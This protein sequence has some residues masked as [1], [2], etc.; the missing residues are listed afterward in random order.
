MKNVKDYLEE[1]DKIA[2][3]ENNEEAIDFL[4][5]LPKE[6]KQGFRKGLLKLDEFANGYETVEVEKNSFHYKA[7][8]TYEYREIL[9]LGAIATCTAKEMNKFQS[10]R[11]SL[12]NPAS[13][14]M[15][16]YFKPTWLTKVIN[17]EIGRWWGI[18]SFLAVK[19][20]EKKGYINRFEPEVRADLLRNEPALWLDKIQVSK[21]R[22]RHKLS[23]RY[24][25]LSKEEFNWIKADLFL[26]FEYDLVFNGNDGAWKTIFKDWCEQGKIKR[27]QLITWTFDTFHRPFNRRTASFFRDFLDSLELSTDEKLALQDRYIEMLSNA[28]PHHVSYALKEIKKL[29]KLAN[30][31]NENLVENLEPILVSDSKGTVKN[32]LMLLERTAKKKKEL[33]PEICTTALLGL[34]SEDSDIQKRVLAILEKFGTKGDETLSDE[35]MIYFENIHPSLQPNFQPFLGESHAATNTES[36]SEVFQAEKISI[37][38]TEFRIKPIENWEDWIYLAGAVYEN[39]T[40]KSVEV[41][42]LF[43]GAVRLYGMPS[44][45]VLGRMKPLIQRIKKTRNNYWSQPQTII[46]AFIKVIYWM[47]ETQPKQWTLVKQKATNQFHDQSFRENP[48][49][50][51]LVYRRFLMYLKLV[52]KKGNLPVL[53]AP[54]HYHAW[55]D[56]VIFIEKLQ[57]YFNKNQTPIILDLAHALAKLSLKDTKKAH[58]QAQKIGGKLG[59]I[60]QVVLGNSEKSPFDKSSNLTISTQEKV[61]IDWVL[62]DFSDQP[63]AAAI[64]YLNAFRTRFPDKN[65]TNFK[66]FDYENDFNTAKVGRYLWDSIQKKE[67]YKDSEG[68]VYLTITRNNFFVKTATENFPPPEDELSILFLY[69]HLWVD[70]TLFSIDTFNLEWLISLLPNNTET[71]FSFYNQQFGRL[72][73]DYDDV[74]TNKASRAILQTIIDFN[75][76]LQEMG[77]LF[78][79]CATTYADKVSR[80]MA[81]EVLIHLLNQ[82]AL[83]LPLFSENIGKLA[84]KGYGRLQRIVPCLQ[85]ASEVSSFHARAIQMAII[86][87]LQEFPTDRL[88]RNTKKLLELLLNLSLTNK[89]VVDLLLFEKQMAFWRKNTGLKK[90][91]KQFK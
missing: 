84:N 61:D 70:K 36:E 45:D 55:I 57:Q 54:T 11:S 22:T 8:R 90:L 83:N 10:G 68:K 60:I 20:Y 91:L 47:L 3:R 38:S 67:H 81:T 42:R 14:L 34:V 58:E 69:Q 12:F 40:P 37:L 27:S 85:Q 74:E 19:R 48:I 41:E 88:P 86:S 78:L 21:N 76:P 32:A 50:K 82:N 28:N 51:R 62:T 39:K 35:L 56:P 66:A 5:I 13:E 46:G 63:R 7:H 26:L 2:L 4:K 52:F 15:I 31:N 80:G 72:N 89:Q 25:E 64:L 24:N 53:S 33:L 43:E 75:I 1:F 79:A 23:T 17:G 18:R 44:E 49:M 16:A 73:S 65:M 30:F 6:V 29:E 87:I 59:E 9:L 71:I 77:M